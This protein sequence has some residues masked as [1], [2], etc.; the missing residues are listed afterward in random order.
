MAEGRITPEKEL[1]NLI[2]G[3]KNNDTGQASKIALKRKVNS[4][5]SFG[6]AIGRLSFFKDYLKGAVKGKRFYLD[7]KAT[8]RIL[9]FCIVTLIAFFIANFVGSLMNSKKL[10]NLEFNVASAQP[11]LNFPDVSALKPAS[12]YLENAKTRNIFSLVAETGSKENEIQAARA[13]I[14]ELLQNLKLVGI[15]WSDDPD[16]IIEDTKKKQAFFLKKGQNINEFTIKDVYKDRVVLS[17]GQENV[18]LR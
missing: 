11:P 16:I 5:L 4:F 17:Y 15:S 6:A 7:I 12:Y 10:L 3:S 8:N 14:A 9:A 2:E 18:E 13:K 1:L